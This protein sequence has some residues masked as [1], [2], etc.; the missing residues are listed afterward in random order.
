MRLGTERG[1]A[2]AAAS[3]R[4]AAMWL[5]LIIMLS[6][7]MFFLLFCASL[8]LKRA[9]CECRAWQEGAMGKR[10]R[11]VAGREGR[12]VIN[13]TAYKRPASFAMGIPPSFKLFP[14][15]LPK[16]RASLDALELL[17]SAASA[18]ESEKKE[19]R[20]GA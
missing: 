6:V 18:K 20:K 19:E 3:E 1:G 12:G 13:R 4:I 7:S 9:F 14:R 11:F 15:W 5:P 10:G 8:S 16:P 17:H 2:A